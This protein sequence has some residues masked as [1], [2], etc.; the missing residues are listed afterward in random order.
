M[1]EL[2]KKMAEVEK[3]QGDLDFLQKATENAKPGTLKINAGDNEAGLRYEPIGQ[4]DCHHRFIDLLGAEENRD[5]MSAFLRK[6]AARGRDKLLMLQAEL[7]AIMIDQGCALKAELKQGGWTEGPSTKTGRVDVQVESPAALPRAT[8][9]SPAMAAP[10][11]GV[12]FD[13]EEE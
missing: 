9:M 5:L 8:S 2:Q 12:P 13:E 1:K 7:S 4:Y 3:L 11:G 10:Y 6:V